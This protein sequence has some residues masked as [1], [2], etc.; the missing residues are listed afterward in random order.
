LCNDLVEFVATIEPYPPQ[1]AFRFLGH[2]EQDL[3]PELIRGEIGKQPAL[4]DAPFHI[5]DRVRV[6]AHQANGRFVGS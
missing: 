4:L 6:H 3:G 5:R 2:L 1:F